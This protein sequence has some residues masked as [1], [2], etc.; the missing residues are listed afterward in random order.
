MVVV[1]FRRT[2]PRLRYCYT[3]FL[4]S[5]VG[6]EYLTP[7]ELVFRGS[8]PANQPPVPQQ[9]STRRLRIHTHTQYFPFFVSCEHARVRVCACACGCACRQNLRQQRQQQPTAVLSS[10]RNKQSLLTGRCEVTL[11]IA[12]LLYSRG[13]YYPVPVPNRQQRAA[14]SVVRLRFDNT[15]RK[16]AIF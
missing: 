1:V 14:V 16:N 15:W 11:I 10:L 9:I 13:H 6:Q 2:T 7:Q 3:S 12:C 4:F 5:A 8:H